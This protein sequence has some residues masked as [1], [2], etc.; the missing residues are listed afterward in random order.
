MDDK[1]RE[2]V[3]LLQ[4]GFPIVPEPFK[5]LGDKLWIDEMA[6]ISRLARLLQKGVIRHLGPF[7][8]GTHLGYS[9]V[10][11]AMDVEPKKIA[12]VTEVLSKKSGITHNYLR[13]GS[14]NVWFTVIAKNETCLKS[15]LSSIEKETGIKDVQLF[16]AKRL[17]KVRVDLE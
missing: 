14:P 7:F 16:P 8:S 4:T 9:G 12:Q 17:F 13:D 3:R 5:A 6:V 2:I 15:L 11:A 10:L 1:D